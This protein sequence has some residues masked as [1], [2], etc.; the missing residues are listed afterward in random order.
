[1][2]FELGIKMLLCRSANAEVSDE[3]PRLRYVEYP[4]NDLRLE[5]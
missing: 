4:T 5:D 3:A 1:M 2:T